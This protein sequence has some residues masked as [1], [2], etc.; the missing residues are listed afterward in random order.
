[1]IRCLNV[2]TNI[3]VI[4]EKNGYIKNFNGF[5]LKTSIDISVP[6]LFFLL[7]LP[8]DCDNLCLTFGS[9]P[10]RKNLFGGNKN[11]KVF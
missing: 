6:I 10:D 5:C 9:T 4:N 11:E 8:G 3:T 1:M 7:T 2:N